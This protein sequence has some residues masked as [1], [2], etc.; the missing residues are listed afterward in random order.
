MSLAGRREGLESC[1]RCAALRAFLALDRE[2]VGLRHGDG[3]EDDEVDE[4]LSLA[5]GVAAADAWRGIMSSR[6]ER[7]EG[8]CMLDKGKSG[9]S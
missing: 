9:A 4:S 5:E 6:G 8:G 3:V 2:V 7:G 1:V